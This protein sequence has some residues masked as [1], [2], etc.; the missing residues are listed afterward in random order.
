MNR[1]W[2]LAAP[3]VL[4]CNAELADLTS[5]RPNERTDLAHYE[6]I[7][8]GMSRQQVKEIMG[9][10]AGETQRTH[11]GIKDRLVLVYSGPED[12]QLKVVFS[13]GGPTGYCA[14]GKHFYDK[15]T[16]VASEPSSTKRE[17]P[18][19]P[20]KEPELAVQE[21][22]PEEPDAEDPAEAAEQPVAVQP[23]VEEAGRPVDAEPQMKPEADVPGGGYR[24]WT[25]IT[26]QYQT[27]AEFVRREDGKVRLRKPTGEEIEMP[28][29]R[30][31]E[32]DRQWIRRWPV[33][34]PAGT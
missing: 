34:Q 7:E 10:A 15:G 23:G 33:E 20:A 9:A 19:P 17:A 27:E 11:S 4:G 18:G 25:D 13:P 32:D 16:L 28:L 1:V 3:L 6:K 30:L 2:I 22:A 29:E 14:V 26:G 24:T 8:L 12:Q 5:K 21:P 31:S